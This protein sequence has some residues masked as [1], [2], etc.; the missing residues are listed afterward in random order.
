MAEKEILSCILFIV[1]QYVK[2]NADFVSIKKIYIYKDKF[3]V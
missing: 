3:L 1:C 2:T